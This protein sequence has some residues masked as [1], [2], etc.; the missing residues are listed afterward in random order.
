MIGGYDS[1]TL[2]CVCTVCMALQVAAAD[3]EPWPGAAAAWG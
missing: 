3:L 1:I 2:L